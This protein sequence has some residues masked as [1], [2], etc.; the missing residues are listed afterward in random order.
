MT[1][2]ATPT[3]PQY[4]GIGSHTAA[5][6]LTADERRHYDEQGYVVLRGFFSQAELA[7]WLQRLDDIITGRVPKPGTMLMM[8]D[9]MVAKGR[10]QAARPQDAI[11]KIQDLQDDSVFSTYLANEKLLDVIENF[12]GPN[13]KTVHNMLINKPPGVDG[14]HPLHQDL[15]YFPFR[16]ADNIV[17]TWTAMERVNREN[18]CLAVIPGSHKG[19]LL[20]HGNLPDGENINLAYFGAKNIDIEQR[21][22]LEMD[23]GDVLFFHPVLLHGSGRNL[24]RGCRRA[25]SAHYAAGECQY[26]VNGRQMATVRHYRLVRGHEIPEGI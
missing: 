7:P 1:A 25:I 19:G 2:Y 4:V 17:A 11:A 26:T 8:K 16:P 10:V 5:R 24:S 3:E 22:H 14:R 18:G 9:I 6:P 20:E 13:I 15:L 21:V 12:C 23:A